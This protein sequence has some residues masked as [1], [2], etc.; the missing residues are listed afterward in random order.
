MH[1]IPEKDYEWGLQLLHVVEKIIN[2]IQSLL[3]IYDLFLPIIFV[4]YNWAP[5][6]FVFSILIPL[7]FVVYLVSFLFSVRY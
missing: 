6:Y 4:E 7:F 2:M 1:G 3:Y 5:T